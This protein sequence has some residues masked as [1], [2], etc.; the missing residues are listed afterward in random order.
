MLVCWEWLAEYV[1]LTRTPDEMAE[2]FAM[3]GL[4]HES[5]TQVGADTVIDLEVT[6]NRGDCLG[7]I[8]VAREASVL[9]KQPL[10]IPDPQPKTDASQSVASYLKIENRF[11]EGCPRYTAR[12]IL[13]VKIG[14]SP[15]WLV[16]RLAAVGMNSVNNVVDVT[17]YVMMECGQPL[18]AFDLDRVAERTIIVRAARAGEEFYAIDHKTYQLDEQMV[19]I[20]D[21]RGA[22][23]LGG[24]MG[25]AESE[26]SDKTVNLVIESAAFEPLAIR[27][28]ARKLKLDSAASF[29][30]ERRPDP[31]GLDWASRRCCEL[32]LKVAGGTL[33][34]GVLDTG[35]EP[36]HSA[37]IAFRLNQIDRVIGI[38]V[39]RET[40]VEILSALG[41]KVTDSDKAGDVLEVVPP[42]WRKDLT[43]EIDFVEEVARIYGYD[44]IP[45]NAVVPLGVAAVR[46]KDIVLQRVRHVLSA[47]G[48]DE[49]LTPSVVTGEMDEL[50]SPWSDRAGLSTETPLLKGARKLRRSLLPSLLTAR[51]LNQTQAGRDAWLY[52]VATIYLPGP[53]ESSLPQEQ[54]TLAFVIGGDLSYTKGIVEELVSQ[55][56]SRSA[57]LE[58]RPYQHTLYVAGTATEFVLDGRRLGTVGL[59]SKSVAKATGLDNSTAAAELSV[60]ALIPALEEIRTAAQ[61]SHYP[62]VTRDLNFILDE[63][64]R[65]SQLEVVCR[66]SGGPLLQQV[67]YR[68]TYRD[69]KKDGADKKRVLLT[70]V[71]QSGERTLTSGEVDA[72][73]V[74]VTTAVESDCSGKLLG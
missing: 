63:S 65:W 59:V 41:C 19:V 12:V 40:V 60:D 1:S 73:V 21:G 68:E 61:V 56:T 72:A 53:E 66:S 26:V 31:A 39:L 69:A 6:S 36:E 50:G 38:S 20:G 23:A 9:L 37:P 22:A 44:K 10:K 3:S 32:I 34:S 70:L 8:G 64:L 67:E 46:P 4:N 43:R 17:N 52:E 62:A 51:V 49:A 2:M 13:G 25:G 58:S 55:V 29:R 16:R 47:Y 33:V 48:V 42:S 45:E 7:H 35:R 57:K 71:F 54:S 27:R 5:T 30:F 11:V 24:V 74:S 15:A 28:A 14:P 18:H